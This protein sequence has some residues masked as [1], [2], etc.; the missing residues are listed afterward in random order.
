MDQ[1]AAQLVQAFESHKIAAGSFG[2][3]EH[4]RVAHELLKRH[5]YLE[6]SQ[7]FA[8][9]ASA[10]ATS[11]GVPE[12]FNV[13]ITLAFLS[14]IAE[15]LNRMPDVGIDDFLGSNEDLLSKDMLRRW[16]SPAELESEFAR[17]HLLLPKGRQLSR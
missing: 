13:T 4:V 14:A 16:Y 17:T 6:A 3:E 5:G 7:R 11:A 10:L 1:N 9:A 8:T 2:H 15:R 12:K